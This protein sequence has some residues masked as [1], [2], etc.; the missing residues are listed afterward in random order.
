M[1]IDAVA[2]H[3]L[4]CAGIE[5]SRL[6][7]A[8]VQPAHARGLG[9]PAL[10]GLAGEHRSDVRVAVFLRGVIH[11]HVGDAQVA[12]AAVG[13]RYLEPQPL[14]AG[15]RDDAPAAQLRHLRRV[16]V[17]T[18]VAPDIP[19]VPALGHY[20]SSLGPHAPAQPWRAGAEK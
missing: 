10:A 18:P 9:N 14:L 12:A 13:E 7:R 2:F 5:R 8:F 16:E 1:P 19:L 20:L 11:A 15:Y 6:Q 4:Q 17:R 3:R